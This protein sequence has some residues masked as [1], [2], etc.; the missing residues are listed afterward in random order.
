M[1]IFQVD[2]NFDP[3]AMPDT[4]EPGPMTDMI[5]DQTGPGEEGPPPVIWDQDQ[6]D[7]MDLLQVWIWT[8]DGPGTNGPPPGDM[9]PGGWANGTSSR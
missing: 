1:V 5:W 4:W 2:Q 8:V 3:G 7:H 6:M 9:G